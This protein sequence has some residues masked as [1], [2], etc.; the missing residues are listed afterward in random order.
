VRRIA[1]AVQNDTEGAA[2]TANG[3]AWTGRPGNTRSRQIGVTAD[4]AFIRSL[5]EN[6]L[7]ACH[8]IAVFSHNCLQASA[9]SDFNILSAPEQAKGPF[10][11]GWIA[12]PNI[13]SNAGYFYVRLPDLK[14][15][16]SD[17]YSA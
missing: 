9:L 13:A 2:A 16:E 1:D 10:E 6:L 12:V 7:W 8:Q 5:R 3:G 15:I 11:P 14:I 17:D 4:C